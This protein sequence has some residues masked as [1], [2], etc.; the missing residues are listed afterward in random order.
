MQSSIRPS[1][2]ASS[3]LPLDHWWTY[4][5]P[6][7]AAVSHLRRKRNRPHARA[8]VTTRSSLFRRTRLNSDL[9]VCELTSAESGKGTPLTA[10]S[11]FYASLALRERS[12]TRGEAPFLLWDRLRAKPA[13]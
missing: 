10:P 7:C 12:W 6:P 3:T 9:L 13:G 5:K 4:G 1:L 8:S 2:G 11:T